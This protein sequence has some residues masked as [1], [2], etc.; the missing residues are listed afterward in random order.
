MSA[1]LEIDLPPGVTS[2]AKHLTSAGHDAVLVGGAVRDAL[3]GGEVCDLDLVTDAGPDIV[4]AIAEKAEGV[5][6]VYA[7]GERFGTLGVAL[8]G[9]GVL[10][11]SAYRPA[12][13][14]EVTLSGRFAADAGQRDFTVNAIGV[15]LADGALLDPL[16]GGDD[17]AARLLKAP[18]DPAARFAEDPLRVLRGARLVAQLGFELEPRTAA[19]M[20]DAAGGLRTVAA[21]RIRV[22][23]TKL[24][25]AAHALE[26]LLAAHRSGALSVALPEVAALDGVTQPSF[27]DLD[28]LAHTFQAV[29]MA[30]REPVLRWAAL[31]HD[32]G[33]GPARSVDPDGRIRFFGHAQ[34]GALIAERICHRLRFSNND[35]AAIVHLVAE[36]MRL[37]EVNV[38]NPRSVDRAVR[39]LD[40]A[41][42]AR[43]LASAED[44]LELTVADFSATAHR[45]EAAAVRRRLEV[46][47]AESRARGSRVAVRS[48][49]S[50][51]ELMTELGITE[52]PGVGVAKQAIIASIADGTIEQDDREAALAIAAKALAAM[53]ERSA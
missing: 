6:R 28:V 4:R 25:T 49:L 48:P 11:V 9:G 2:M 3:L 51:G 15:S 31:L 5:H 32:V 23:L 21:E 38:S 10:E 7:V 17:L 16:D 39:R 52:G 19:A 37:G 27:H 41:R 42:G 30:P 29:G 45:G 14:D 53:S 46:A 50:G 33:K 8:E 1:H 35:T 40:L 47:L 18:R 24:L 36:H 43:L 44:A 20:A 12:A 26:G 22:E 34:I 13:R